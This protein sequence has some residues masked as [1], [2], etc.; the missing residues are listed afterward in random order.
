MLRSTEFLNVSQGIERVAGLDWAK[1]GGEGG[2]GG[3]VALGVWACVHVRVPHNFAMGDHTA[4][5][6]SLYGPHFNNNLYC[7]AGQ[8]SPSIERLHI[9]HDYDVTRTSAWQKDYSVQWQLTGRCCCKGD[10]GGRFVEFIQQ[11]NC[12]IVTID[13]LK[14]Y[15]LAF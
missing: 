1:M 3:G 14:N 5:V 4:K 11:S 15:L 13:V 6:S 7:A 12:A 8:W 10:I 9:R 2:E